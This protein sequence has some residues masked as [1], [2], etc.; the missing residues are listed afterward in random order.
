MKHIVCSLVLVLFAASLCSAQSVL[1][2][3]Q[4]VDGSS[5]QG[6][7]ASAVAISNPAAAGTATASGT[8][9]VTK[10]DGTPL[11]ITFV[12]DGLAPTTNTFQLA[13]G[14]TKIFY[15]PTL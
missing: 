15:S 5:G 14:Q 2:F 7:W 3:P 10:F 4:F 13:G 1:Y 11:N 6:F 9:T 8:V 12:D